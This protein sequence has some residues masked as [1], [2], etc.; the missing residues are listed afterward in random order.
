MKNKGLAITLIITLS[1]ISISLVCLM[2]AVINGNFNFSN[3]H[4]NIGSK[5]SREVLYDETYEK[6]FTKLE[7]SANYSNVRIKHSNND[8]FKLVIYSDDKDFD[9]EETDN[10]LS[11]K[12]DEKKCFGFCFYKTTSV[13]EL[14]VPEDYAHSLVITNKYG[15]VEIEELINADIDTNSDCGDVSIKA[16]NNLTVK[17]DYGDVKI[18]TVKTADIKQSAGDV[19][20]EEVEDVTIDSDLGDVEIDTITKHVNIKSDCGTVKIENLDLT[21][22]SKIV[23]NVGDIRINST[24][25]I[26]FDAKTDL[27]D[28]DIENNY[29]KSDVT[30]KLENDCDDIKIKN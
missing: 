4:F 16:A 15:D 29:P 23:N 1:I 25:K 26:Y 7:I 5:E 21:K 30:I 28:I 20:I 9:I 18:G 10:I 12:Q 24:G 3:M 11:I 22:N 14:Y 27:G 6:D 13:V 17:S 2:L 8:E 19:E